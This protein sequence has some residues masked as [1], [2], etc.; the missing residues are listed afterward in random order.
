MKKI[1]LFSFLAFSIWGMAQNTNAELKVKLE[2]S[3]QKKLSEYN[4]YVKK[5]K[6]NQELDLDAK[7]RAEE[8]SKL[9]KKRKSLAFFAFGRPYYYIPMDT[10][11]NRNVN[12]DLIQEGKIKGL[13]QAFNGEGIHVGVFD[14]GRVYAEHEDFGDASRI[15]NKEKDEQPYSSHSTGVTDMMGG[16][17]H[18]LQDGQGGIYNTKGVL[19]KATFESYYFDDSVLK[20]QTEELTLIQ[21][22]QQ[23]KNYL[24]NHSYGINGQWEYDSDLDKYI[25]YGYY[26]PTSKKAYNFDGS[27]FDEDQNYDDIVYTNPEMVIVKAAGN[28]YGDGPNGSAEDAYYYDDNGNKKKFKKS[29]VVPSNNCSKGYDCISPGSLAKNII[30]VGAT[31]KILKNDARFKTASDV[32]KAGYSSAGPRDDGAVKPDIAGVGSNI[33]YASYDSGKKKGSWSIGDGTSFATPQVTAVIGLWMEI[34]KKLFNKQLLN[35]AAAKTLL[36]HSAH[37]VG[38]VGPDSWSGWGFADAAEG[39]KILVGKS[40]NTAIFE[41]KTLKDGNTD[42]IEVETDGKQ[43]LKVTVSWIDPSYKGYGDTWG[44]IYNNR[45]SCL[46]NDLDVRVIDEEDNTVYYPWKLDADHPLTVATKGDNT[47]DNVE[48]ILIDAPKAGKYK[49][50]ITNKK[51]LLDNDG[52][53]TDTQNYSIAV[54]GYTKSNLGINELNADQGIEIYPS[55]AVDF[56]TFTHPEDIAKIFIYDTSGNIVYSSS[57][58]LDGKINVSA[59]LPG[60]YVVDIFMPHGKVVKKFIKK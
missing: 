43:P 59:F 56:I 25:W 44:E 53:T 39:A 41:N 28:S 57:A 31:E 55:L 58:I 30:V 27:Y 40:N 5:R 20:G 22:I 34:S 15:T 11:Q 29:D 6:S 60:L 10:V 24:S 36:I 49:I 37:D 52:K 26:S 18:T 32:K 46:V 9:E 50:K 4:L 16:I 7:S 21:K 47:V 13:A 54:T 42:E 51:H 17:G 1:V 23:S 33:I 35:A 48:Q 14:G 3:K 2:K 38:N 45:K 12:A 19:S 8:I